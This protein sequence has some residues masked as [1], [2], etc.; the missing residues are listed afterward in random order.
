MYR[1]APRELITNPPPLD[2]GERRDRFDRATM[3][4]LFKDLLEQSER[5]FFC[6]DDQFK[7]RHVLSTSPFSRAELERILQLADDYRSALDRG[8]RLRVMDGKILATMFYEP[9]TR[10]RL[11]FEAAMHRLGGSVISTA[12]GNQSSSAV[13]GETITDSVRV[14]AG[15]ADVIVQ[16]H[17]AIGS[18]QEAADAASPY[19]I[20][21]INA[22]DGA[23]EH[24]SQAMLD[25]FTMQDERGR[26]DGLHVVLS[27][28]LKHGRTVHSLLKALCKWDDVRVT[29]VAPDALHMPAD[30]VDALR[31]CARITQT[32]D[33]DAA[34]RDADVLYMTRIQKER[35]AD[36]ADYARH[37][38]RFVVDAA[39]MRRHPNLTIMHPLPR[40][41][42]IAPEVDAHPN[43]AYFR[44][45]QNG[46]FVRMALL[47]LV[48]GR[49]LPY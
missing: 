32:D 41:D 14:L 18:A 31:N 4:A 48:A 47:S 27:G 34:C 46:L 26:L 45:T 28:D 8:E 13:K 39:F 49:T 44:Q 33:L 29:L 23:G 2:R 21:V 16:R 24:P 38:G 30:I 15:Y 37:K 20:P 25:L 6:E 19:N 43:A 3:E 12:D 7:S 1:T 9:S 11:S 17:P 36:P 42:E 10:T 40:V 35:F 22:G 5:S